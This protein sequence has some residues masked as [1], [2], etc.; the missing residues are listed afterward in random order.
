MPFGNSPI[1]IACAVC[2][3]RSASITSEA[4]QSQTARGNS[5]QT[6][7]SMS[8]ARWVRR[9]TSCEASRV[10]YDEPCHQQHTTHAPCHMPRVDFARSQYQHCQRKYHTLRDVP[11]SVYGYTAFKR[12]NTHALRSLKRRTNIA[13]MA[14]N[15]SVL[16]IHFQNPDML[17][18]VKRCTYY[19]PISR[20]DVP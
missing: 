12:E 7:I 8:K 15:P 1:P 11:T 9:R 6:S 19:A 5:T 13:M 10:A 17:N 4:E 16:S 2:R 14:A 20:P 18:G 3:H